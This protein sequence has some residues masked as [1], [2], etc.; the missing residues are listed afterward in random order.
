[1][2]A[3]KLFD[4]PV[5]L[6]A[7]DFATQLY[8][9]ELLALN[10]VHSM[11]F[12]LVY[13]DGKPTAINDSSAIMAYFIQKFRA[14]I[15]ESFAPSDPLEMAQVNE[16]V[17]F[18]MGVCYRSTMYQYVYPTMGLM[19]E[20]QYDACKRDFCLD[21]VEGWAKA[22]ESKFFGEA[23][24]YADLCWYS[25][26]LGNNWIKT[27]P[28]LEA[29]PWTH[30][31]AIDKYPASKA[32]IEACGELD[33]VK[34]VDDWAQFS[35]EK[36]EDGSPKIQVASIN[37]AIDN[38]LFGML[39]MDKMAKVRGFKIDGDTIH[40]NMVPYSGEAGAAFNTVVEKYA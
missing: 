21:I 16:K 8:S 20:C 13:K 37:Y 35:E 27:A 32:I 15:P 34:Q 11:P 28:G 26:W 39:S 25:L 5:D 14:Q 10:P 33:A 22:S 9:P 7:V 29:L 30:A 40:P 2:Y 4:L 18:I 31:G 1:M 36:N 17:S 23:V 6:C 24:S 12:L 19:T 3:V 38:G